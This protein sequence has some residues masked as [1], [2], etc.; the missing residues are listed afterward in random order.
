MLVLFAYAFP[1][2]KSFNF[3]SGMIVHGKKP[4]VVIAAPWENLNYRKPK[5]RISEQGMFYPEIKLVCMKNDIEYI[6]LPHNSNSS[7]NFLKTNKP[8]LGVVAGA[9]IL[10]KEV[11]DCFSAGILNFHPGL[12]PYVRGLD[13]VK[14]SILHNIPQGVTAH[15]IDEKIDKGNLIYRDI[16]DVQRD[17]S[18][19]EIMNRLQN[20]ELS[21][22]FNLIINY[23]L[24]FDK[25]KKSFEKDSENYFSQIPENLEKKVEEI[26]DFYKENYNFIKD[27]H[28]NLVSFPNNIPT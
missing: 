9:R 26:F 12:L 10:K 23:N 27:K 4:D 24:S 28:A 21:F 22:F 20:M 18:F 7:I 16:L 15:L 14:W 11:I 17:D 2:K 1:H 13:T 3:L 5:I 8:N 6:Q 19:I 25:L